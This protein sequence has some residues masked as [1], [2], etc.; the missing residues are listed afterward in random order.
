[1]SDAGPWKGRK[2]SS[3]R[4]ESL[5]QFTKADGGAVDAAGVEGVTNGLKKVELGN[6]EGENKEEEKKEEG[7]GEIVK[8]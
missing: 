2:G 6:G 7:N 3:V 5:V 1:M 4:R 8:V